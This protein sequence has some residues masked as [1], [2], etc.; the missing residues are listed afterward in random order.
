[1]F[2]SST[3]FPFAHA[4]DRDQDCA[5]NGCYYCEISEP[6]ENVITVWSIWIDQDSSAGWRDAFGKPHLVFAH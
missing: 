4:V 3:W 1:M 5:S 6:M 2:S